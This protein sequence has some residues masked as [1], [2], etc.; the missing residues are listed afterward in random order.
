VSPSSQTTIVLASGNK[1]KL[2]EL[3]SLLGQG[4]SI[5]SAGDLGVELPEETGTT[6]EENAI[7][8]ASAVAKQIGRLA[9]ADDSGLEVDALDGA[10]GVYSA[11]Y[12]GP[13]A[14]DER[15]RLK[16]LDALAGLDHPQRT[17]R[18]RCV[19]AIAFSPDDIVTTNGSCEGH[20]TTSER[21]S[22]GFGYDPLFEVAGGK[23]MAELDP[24]EKNDVS[25]RGHAMRAAIPVLRDRLALSEVRR[26]ES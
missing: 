21:G 1:G 25:H 10:P 5:L 23:T 22:G 15:N 13:E 20:I 14:D 19:I 12:A 8:K 16:L 2:E 7:L 18:F 4:V 11:R 24:E 17:A 26:E 9:I 3:R 6:F